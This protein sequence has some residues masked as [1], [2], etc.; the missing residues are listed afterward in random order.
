[1]EIND[2]ATLL[3]T[4]TQ[5]LP[6]QTVN[7]PAD[8]T[9]EKSALEELE[10]LSGTGAAG[11]AGQTGA[12]TG[13]SSML[14]EA[15]DELQQKLL[16][17]ALSDNADMTTSLF[18]QIASGSAADG[19]TGPQLTGL[20][21][22]LSDG[23]LDSDS[24]GTLAASLGIDTAAGTSDSGREALLQN[25]S[26]LSAFSALSGFGTNLSTWQN[27]L[28]Q[29]GVEGLTDMSDLTGLDA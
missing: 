29:A 14:T 11:A 22:L 24:L 7:S 3:K 19:S 2:L 18:S 8:G 20:S 12:A 17:N 28:K 21:E 23:G 26:N 25:F 16:E 6:L 4:Y 15:V 27:L 10:A 13:F 1:M 9:Q 5:L